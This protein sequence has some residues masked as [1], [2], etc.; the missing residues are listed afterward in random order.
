MIRELLLTI[1]Q[2]YYI[3][4]KYIVRDID[5]NKYFISCWIVFFY[6]LLLPCFLFMIFSLNYILWYYCCC[7]NV[8]FQIFEWFSPQSL[9][10]RQQW[11]LFF[12]HSIMIS[13]ISDTSFKTCLDNSRHFKLI[14]NY[15]VFL[16]SS[17]ALHIFLQ[18]INYYW[19]SLHLSYF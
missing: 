9:F 18:K 12:K 14:W 3:F 2:F 8:Y 10:F 11:S 16:L 7:T 19:T 17:W 5:V 4:W 1:L 15:L 13:L 6:Y